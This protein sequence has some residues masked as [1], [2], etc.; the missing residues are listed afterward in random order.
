[1]GGNLT[2]TEIEAELKKKHKCPYCNKP[3]V[4]RQSYGIWQC[5][6]CQKKFAGKAYTIKKKIVSEEVKNG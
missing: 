3:A 6:S 1:M 4:K 2:R 5:K